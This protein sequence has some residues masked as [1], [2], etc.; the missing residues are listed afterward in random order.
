MP[1]AASEFHYAWRI[2]LEAAGEA[3]LFGA[4][5]EQPLRCLAEQP[6][7]ARVHQSERGRVVECEHRDVDLRHHALQEGGGFERAEPALLQFGH[8]R[9]HLEHREA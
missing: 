1:V 8:Q 5:A 2:T 3:E 7:A 6:L 4:P 9:V